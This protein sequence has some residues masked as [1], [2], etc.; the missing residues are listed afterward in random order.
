MN[1]RATFSLMNIWWWIY[2]CP[3]GYYVKLSWRFLLPSEG[4]PACCDCCASLY[5]S[6]T[7]F[8]LLA[9][10]RY[11]A[12]NLFLSSIDFLTLTRSS[13]S[14]FCVLLSLC[15]VCFCLETAAAVEHDAMDWTAGYGW[16]W[17][18]MRFYLVLGTEFELSASSW[19]ATLPGTCS[20]LALL[21]HH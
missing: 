17:L 4:V 20:R 9:R 14:V 11:H 18:V 19:T 3:L 16:L 1:H 7:A 2:F 12:I 10:L 6:Y 15:P 5:T 8:T 21:K 13:V